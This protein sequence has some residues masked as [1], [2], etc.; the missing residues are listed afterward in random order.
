MSDASPAHDP[1]AT[2]RGLVQAAERIV[3]LTGAGISTDSGIPDYRGP[4]GVWTR[5]PGAERRAT[6]DAYVADGEV[7]RQ[8]WQN[9][10][11]SG[12][13][14][15]R[16][17]AGH[18]ALVDL[19]RTGRLDTLITQNIDGLHL[20]AGSDP[21]RVVEVHG[22]VRQFVCLACDRRGPMPEALDRVRAGDP[23]PA[24]LVCGGIL[25]SATISFGQSLVPGDLERAFEAAAR[26]DLFLAIGSTLSVYPVAETVPTALRA[27]ADLI[28]LNGEPTSFDPLADVVLHARI[29]EVLPALVTDVAE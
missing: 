5:N 17:N 6:I 16:P 24:C 11:G 1:V 23:D 3:V 18:L 28:I 20:A 19:E 12:V 27:G 25:K 21:A 13:W 4:D 22:N 29:G 26:C 10:L 9:R 15:A 2:A 8:A 7:R 14:D